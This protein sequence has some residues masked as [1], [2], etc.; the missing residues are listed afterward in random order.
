MSFDVIFTFLFEKKRKIYFSK[1]SRGY[2]RYQPYAFVLI[3][4]YKP[5]KT[6]LFLDKI[7]KIYNF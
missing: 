7:I 2:F 4:K 3:C 5:Y 6:F 1:I